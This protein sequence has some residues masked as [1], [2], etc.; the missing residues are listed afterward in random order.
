MAWRDPSVR[1]EC[2]VCWSLHEASHRLYTWVATQGGAR[3]PTAGGPTEDESSP[4]GDERDGHNDEHR[5]QADAE[6]RMV[7][8]EQQ[9]LSSSEDDPYQAGEPTSQELARDLKGKEENESTNPNVRWRPLSGSTVAS[10]GTAPTANC[11]SSLPSKRQSSGKTQE[12]TP[13]LVGAEVNTLSQTQNAQ[14]PNEARSQ[15][16]R[17]DNAA[18]AV[19]TSN[20]KGKA[21]QLST[22]P[23]EGQTG[24]ETPTPK[25]PDKSSSATPGH[26]NDDGGPSNI[27][28]LKR[29]ISIL[30]FD[31]LT[32]ETRT[33]CPA[34]EATNL[35]PAYARPRSEVGLP[36][37]P[38]TDNGSSDEDDDNDMEFD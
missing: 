10:S 37:L 3:L 18:V 15:V 38:F 33:A 12:A 4:S 35:T 2:Q 17:D 26:Q 6:G 14:S 9:L 20:E 36:P 13:L 24:Q 27:G 29:T 32:E 7:H 34:G 5:R 23:A 1:K 31:D 11:T 28:A 8:K 19:E 30:T 22:D 25:N 16:R 21:L